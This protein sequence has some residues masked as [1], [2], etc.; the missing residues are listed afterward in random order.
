M[1]LPTPEGD[2]GDS[3]R[4]HR[5]TPLPEPRLRAVEAPEERALS[6]EGLELVY[7]ALERVRVEHDLRRLTVAVDDTKLGAQLLVVPRGTRGTVGVDPLR[8]WSSDP[9]L[10]GV[11]LDVELVVALCRLAL[12]DATGEEAPTTARDALEVALRRLDGVEAASIDTGGEVLGVQ[13][14]PGAPPTVGQTVLEVVK[15]RLDHTAV[16]ELVGVADGDSRA[17]R[18]DAIAWA[19]GGALELVAVRT[20]D[21]TGELEVHL[22]G[23]E[24]RTIGRSATRGLVGA[25]EAALAAWHARPGAAARAIGWART[26]ETSSD[27]TVVVAVALEDPRRVTVAHGIGSGSDPIRAAAAATVDALSR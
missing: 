8:G 7:A 24:I 25:A 9:P 12:R 21:P 20:E 3:S 26:V 18:P 16:V 2:L 6:S 10:P 1:V 19:P 4:F 13:T 14:G 15:E 27:G 17:G 11:P 23:G 5:V 22:R